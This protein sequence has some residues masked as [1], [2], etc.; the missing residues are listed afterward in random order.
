MKKNNRIKA[1]AIADR[2]AFESTIDEIAALTVDLRACQAARDARVI[3]AQATH[4]DEIAQIEEKIKAKAALCEKFAEEH[5]DELLAGK[6][7]SAETPLARYGFRLGNRTVALLNRKITWD[8]IIGVLKARRYLGL[9]RTV[10]EVDKEAVL[11]ATDEFGTLR[12]HRNVEGHNVP[13]STAL[14]SLGL[15][16]K[17]TETFYIEPKVDGAE[18]VKPATAA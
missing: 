12:A 17:Q 1:P 15:K 9:I 14:V 18:T 7:K 6:A 5:R 10:E 11:R 3:I 8:E 2:L 13:T 4:A 16:I